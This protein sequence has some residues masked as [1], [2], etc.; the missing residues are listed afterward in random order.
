MNEASRGVWGWAAALALLVSMGFSWRLL[1]LACSAGDPAGRF[2]RGRAC[3]PR[4]AGRPEFA[5][6]FRN[7]LADVAW[8][9]AV[10]VAGNRK[11]T[12]AEYDRL[13]DLL[14]VVANFDPKF[15]MPYLLGRARPRRVAASRAESSA[16]SR[17]GQG[18]VP[19]RLALPLLHGVHALLLPRRRGGRGRGD[20]G[21]GAV[22]GEPG[23][24]AGSRDPDAVG[25][26][27]TGGRAGRCWRRSSGRRATPRDGRCWSAGSGKSTVERDLQ[28]LERAVEKYREKTGAVPARSVRIS[29]G[30]G[31]SRGSRWN[32]TAGA[33]CS[34]PGGKVRSDRVA[35]RLRVFQKK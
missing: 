13:Y 8:L 26:E 35:Q 24:P 9:E 10:Q 11:M 18:A 14:N 22:A 5:F 7:V 21:G 1:S 20:G 3:S 19:G 30:R 4:S 28:A 27:G 2:G 25:G 12:P 34:T 31:S 16:G 6:G 15:E 29:S 32:P 17:A 23:L 33:T